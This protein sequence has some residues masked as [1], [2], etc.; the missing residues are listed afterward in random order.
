MRDKSASG[1][2]ESKKSR[3][4]DEI[5]TEINNEMQFQIYLEALS[6]N[7][8]T[9]ADTFICGKIRDKWDAVARE[10]KALIIKARMVP[11]ESLDQLKKEHEK[12]NNKLRTDRRFISRNCV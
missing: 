10:K 1:S 7:L 3:V 5:G 4:D 12:S 8:K 11:Q 2:P 6:E 9:G